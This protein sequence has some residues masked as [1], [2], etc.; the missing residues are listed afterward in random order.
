M[1]SGINYN[2]SSLSWSMNFTSRKFTDLF[3]LSSD[4]RTASFNSNL[5][6]LIPANSRYIQISVVV[7]YF[8]SYPNTV[9]NTETMKATMVLHLSN[10]YIKNNGGIDGFIASSKS[11]NL[12]SGDIVITDLRSFESSDKS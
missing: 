1:S 9:K 2:I 4:L 10:V 8:V 6:T 5:N 7:S 12:L 3:T 11:I